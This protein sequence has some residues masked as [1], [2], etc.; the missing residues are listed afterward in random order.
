MGESTNPGALEQHFD[1]PAYFSSE[2]MELV[3]DWWN[4]T[5]E[6]LNAFKRGEGPSPF[7]ELEELLKPHGITDPTFIAELVISTRFKAREN[8]V[9][10]EEQ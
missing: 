6:R 4:R 3:A 2:V 10:K 5:T 7:G 9:N 8:Q 1:T